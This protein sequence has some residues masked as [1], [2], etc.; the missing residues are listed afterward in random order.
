MKTNIIKNGIILTLAVLFASCNDFLD[1]EPVGK[2]IPTKVSELDN[3]LNNVNTIDFQF[4]DNNRGCFYAQLGDN[5]TISPYQAENTYYATHPNIDRYHAYIFAI[6]YSN[7]V[8]T[9]YFWN[10]GIYRS[11]GLFNNTIAGIQNLPAAESGSDYAKEV[12]AQ[13]KA[14]R[15]WIYLQGGLVYGPAYNPDG[16]NDKKVIPYRT[17]ESP[18]AP[19]PQLSTVSELFDL[20][21]QDLTE[22]VVDVPDFVGTPVRAG[23]VATLAIYAQT[24]MYKRD[25]TQ[26]LKFAD[27]AWKLA[28]QQQ[29]GD[30]D[31]LIYNYNDFEFIETND[32]VVPGADPAVNWSLRH[33]GGD[34]NFRLPNNRENLL[35]RISP[36]GTSLY[37][38]DDY[39]SIFDA[40]SDLRF[41]LFLLKAEGAGGSIEKGGDG[42]Q[43]YNYRGSKLLY[44]EG[45]TYPDLLLM[46]AEA[47]ARTNNKTAALADLNTLRKYR[48]SNS[49]STDL[50]NGSSLST[51]EVLY[52]IIKERRKEQPFESFQRT[53]DI[54]RY[55][56][57]SGKPW[58]KTE[59]IHKIGDRTY[60]A[61]IND[62]Y[63]TLPIDN[64][65]ISLNPEWGLTPD[66]KPYVLKPE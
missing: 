29:G 45:L 32:A 49:A 38:S 15:A 13:A 66:L 62:T 12:V 8:T 30:V 54:K 37:P 27:D 53:L 3:L 33:K 28:L 57:D 6:P 5:I 25:W 61:P 31:K 50:V 4:L 20:I 10:W 2:L 22:A 65:I 21:L 64:P 18:L 46:R 51:D 41:K 9:H 7:P 36:T 34:V 58:S 63:F 19:N 43:R 1:V 59:V 16:A 52:E 56:Y 26:M 60:I 48:Y 42:I 39:L 11:V 35:Y 40:D 17:N 23:K 47:Y 24:Y 55:V 14:A 44:N